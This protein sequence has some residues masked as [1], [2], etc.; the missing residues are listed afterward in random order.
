MFFHPTFLVG[1]F[2]GNAE[3][4]DYGCIWERTEKFSVRSQIHFLITRFFSFYHSLSV[5]GLRGGIPSG[6]Y[7]SR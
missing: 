2:T 7:G 1:W 6:R 3:K 4:N 5:G